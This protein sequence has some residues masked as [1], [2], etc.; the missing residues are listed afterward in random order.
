MKDLLGDS[1]IYQSKPICSAR[2]HR[3]LW[4]SLLCMVSCSLILVGFHM[5]SSQDMIAQLKIYESDECPD[6]QNYFSNV[7]LL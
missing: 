7:D 1:P 3:D 2:P 6:V 5:R 4:L